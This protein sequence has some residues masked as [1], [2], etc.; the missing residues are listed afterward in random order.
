MN[1]P[2]K[3]QRLGNTVTQGTFSF[4]LWFPANESLL[5]LIFVF[6][7]SAIKSNK[8]KQEKPQTLPECMGCQPLSSGCPK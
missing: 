7:L 3:A 4:L 5:E 1:V 6:L 2:A 8:L